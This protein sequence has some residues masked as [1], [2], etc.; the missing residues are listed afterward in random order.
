MWSSLPATLSGAGLAAYSGA[1]VLSNPGDIAGAAIDATAAELRRAYGEPATWT[2][3]RLHL[4]QFRESTL[5][6]SGILPL[7]LYFDPPARPVP[8]ADGAVNN[9]YYRVSRGYAD[10][11]DPDY[12]P[13]GL[14][15]LF[16]VTNGPSYRL[17]VDMGD[18]DGAR[19]VM[20]VQGRC[21]EQSREA[22]RCR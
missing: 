7:E 18:L 1:P 9:T 6:S 10:P 8:G 16:S 17:A 21:G 12:V 11:A 22:W 14:D 19:I 20:G 15:A 2:W 13:V 5:G 4:V 3:G